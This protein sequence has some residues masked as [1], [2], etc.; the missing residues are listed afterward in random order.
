MKLGK[1][2]KATVIAVNIFGLN[3]GLISHLIHGFDGVLHR[4]LMA[5]ARAVERKGVEFALPT[6][7]EWQRAAPKKKT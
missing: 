6:V 4:I 2:K 3:M 7:E 5:I 1:G